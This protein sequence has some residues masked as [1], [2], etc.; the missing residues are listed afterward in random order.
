MSEYLGSHLYELLGIP[1]HQTALG[2]RKGKIVC[3]CKD[4][5][6]PDKRLFMFS[7]LKTAMDDDDPG[8]VESPSDGASVYLTDVLTSI[9]RSEV[10][11]ALPGSRERFWDMFVVDALIKNP[12]RNNGNWGVLMEPN[13]TYSLAPVYDNGS[14]FF[15]KRTDSV[16]ARRTHDPALVEQDAFGTSVS[17]YLVIGQDGKSEHIHPFEYMRTTVNADL[18]KSVLKV[19]KAFDRTAFENLVDSI[20]REAYG[21]TVLSDAAKESHIELVETRFDKGIVPLAGEIAARRAEE[22]A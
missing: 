15:S 6:F 7:D 4:F 21:W 22:R 12:D 17:V 5:T 10:L 3:A 8:F 1:V 2:Y 13:G 20:P 14:S 18:E 19:A 9:E 16:F 11:S